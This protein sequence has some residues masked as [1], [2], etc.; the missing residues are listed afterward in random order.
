[1][2]GVMQMTQES[3]NIFARKRVFDFS[4]LVSE[5]AVPGYS[6]IEKFG[7]NPSVSEGVPEDVWDNGGI[8]VFSS[9]ADIDRIVSSND[10]DI[11][12]VKIFGLDKDWNDVSQTVTLNGQAPVELNVNLVRVYRMINVGIADFEGD[13]YC[14]VN[15]DVTDGVPDTADDIRAMIRAGNNQTLMCIY[16]IPS[17]KVG[18]MKGVYVSVSRAGQQAANVDFTWRAREF[19][20]VFAVK[21]RI[22]CVST[23]SSLWDHSYRFPLRLAEKTDVLIRCEDVSNTCAVSGGFS[24]LLLDV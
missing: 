20:S 5:G 23:G 7:E 6:A 2:K 22:S 17:G 15:G 4:Q 11:Q 8:Y 21:S 12:R 14:F 18:Y 13:V 24:V 9:S 16:T 10:S 1:M 19:G 3:R